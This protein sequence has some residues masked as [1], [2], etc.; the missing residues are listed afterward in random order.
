V[1]VAG[2]LKLSGEARP[3]RVFL[4]SN[5]QFITISG[6]LSGPVIPIMV[7]LKITSSVSLT[8]YEN[9]PILKLDG[10][11]SG[12]LAELKAFFALGNLTNTTTS[13]WTEESINGYTISDGGLFVA[14]E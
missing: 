3:E 13:P 10:S 8:G 9:A 2:T 5:T 14:E 12:N 1:V 7:D 6:P 4:D 11:Y